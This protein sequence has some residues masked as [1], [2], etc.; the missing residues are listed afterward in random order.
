MDDLMKAKH[1]LDDLGEIVCLTFIKGVDEAEALRRLGG[2]PDTISEQAPD[3]LMERLQDSGD[4]IQ[5][6]FSVGLG[7]WSLVI[8]P[9]G[10]CGADHVLLKAASTGVE[11]ISVL[12]HD[13]AHAAFAYAV[14]GDLVTG[15]E[16]GYPDLSSMHGTDS[17]RLWPMMRQ[18]GFHPPTE[19]DG[20]EVWSTSVARALVLAQQ[21]TGVTLPSEPL[22]RPRLHAELEPWFA[23]PNHPEDMLTA[24]RFTLNPHAAPLVAAVEAA[25]SRAQRKL[26][27]AEVRRQAIALGVIDTPGLNDVLRAASDGEF[28][29][30][31]S[32]SPLGQHVRI[33]LATSR[34][35]RNID[36]E[37]QRH[38]NALGWF[39][40]ALRGVLNPDS[41]FAALAAVKPLTSGIPGLSDHHLQRQAIEALR[42]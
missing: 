39:T 14:D 12:R 11:A 27:L 24:G 30:I 33:W 7:P 41:R 42:G 25:D 8:E 37:Q 5:I 10:F 34:N 2:Y 36:P 4:D 20:E 40:G 28:L 16:P 1:L 38:A 21:I 18:I 29:P 9:E 22:S 3:L 35:A 15:F 23:V 19:E 17:H 32:D 6:G 13:Y 26:A 31:R